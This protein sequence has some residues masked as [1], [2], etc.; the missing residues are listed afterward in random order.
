[1]IGGGQLHAYKRTLSLVKHAGFWFR[2]VLSLQEQEVTSPES[3]PRTPV[4]MRLKS[5]FS[6]E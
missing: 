1:M 5:E 3:F 2:G 4:R 6:G